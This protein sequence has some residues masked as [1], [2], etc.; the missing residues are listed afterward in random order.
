MG[1]SRASILLMFPL[2]SIFAI[3]ALVTPAFKS[4]GLKVAGLSCY[5]V[6]FAFV[7]LVGSNVT[8]FNGKQ[9]LLIAGLLFATIF[10]L[11]AMDKPN[12][13]RRGWLFYFALTLIFGLLVAA[14]SSS[15]GGPDWMMIWI[16][17]TLG[18]N[19]LHKAH[20]IVTV[21]RKCI[22]FLGYGAAAFVAASAAYGQMIS[23]KSSLLAG[24]TWPLTLA[25]LD[26]LHQTAFDNRTG[27]LLDILL[28]TLGMATFLCLFWL[29][30]RPAEG[31]HG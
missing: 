22:H 21:I 13:F 7:F 16:N 14:F 19:D 3:F 4:W 20:A 10:A 6:A 12:G 15:A 11:L 1:D 17:D 30:N 28:D 2:P 9:G 8:G 26:E 27:R 29:K 25:I 18:L 5:G 23:L 24:F 31:E